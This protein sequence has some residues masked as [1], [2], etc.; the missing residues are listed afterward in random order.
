LVLPNDSRNV[1]LA[2]GLGGLLV[3]IANGSVYD[4]ARGS[5][6]PLVEG[7]IDLGGFFGS[8]AGTALMFYIGDQKSRLAA[9]KL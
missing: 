4:V 5:V 1:L 7:A 3:M 9:S 2:A 8:I 6:G